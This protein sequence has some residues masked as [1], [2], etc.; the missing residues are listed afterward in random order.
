VTLP[1]AS[2]RLAPK[3]ASESLVAGQIADGTNPT[4][5][6]SG[7]GDGNGSWCRAPSSRTDSGP[8]LDS[9]DTMKP[10]AVTA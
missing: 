4:G 1:A 9:S 5:A 2:T 3:A 8:M 7:P 10:W 6:L